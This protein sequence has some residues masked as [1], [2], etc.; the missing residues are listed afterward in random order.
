MFEVLMMAVSYSKTTGDDSMR[1][2]LTTHSV[3]RRFMS[4]KFGPDGPKGVV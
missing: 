4:A 1:M 2:I 3:Y